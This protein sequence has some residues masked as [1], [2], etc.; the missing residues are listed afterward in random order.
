MKT[1]NKAEVNELF[2]QEAVFFGYRDG[3]PFHRAVRVFGL[4]AVNFVFD[5]PEWRGVWH[6][7]HFLTFEGFS[8]A[9]A[10]YNLAALQKER[11]ELLRNEG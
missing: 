1:Y 4:E 3:V 8:A 7:I 6:H 2:N 9:A 5:E 10:E 11:E